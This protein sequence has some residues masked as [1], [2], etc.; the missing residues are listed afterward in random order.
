MKHK[1]SKWICAVLVAA[2]CIAIPTPAQGAELSTDEKANILNQMYL[3]TGDGTSYQLYQPLKRSEAAAFIVKALGVQNKVLQNQAAYA[4]TSFKDVPA[5]EWYAPY[6]GYCVQNGIISGFPDGKYK[7]ND[8]LSEKAFFSILLKALGYT[9]A[10]FTW[11]W[12]NRK[13]YEVGL[14]KDVSYTF[15]TEDNNTYLRSGVVDT[16]YNALSLKLKNSDKVFVENLIN[17]SMVSREFAGRMGFIKNDSLPT[18]IVATKRTGDNL[19]EITLNESINKLTPNDIKIVRANQTAMS[20][21]V[22]EVQTVENKLFIKT[23]AQLPGQSYTITFSTVTDLEQ[24]VVNG[25]TT[26]F[27]APAVAEITSPYFKIAK[28]EAVNAKS[29]NLYFTHPVTDKAETELL[30]SIYLQDNLFL[31]GS[32]KTISVKKSLENSKMVTLSL[33]ENSFVEGTK[34]TIKV[35]GD[36]VSAYQSYLGQGDGEAVSFVAQQGQDLAADISN[37]YTQDGRYLYINFNNKIDIESALVKSNYSIREKE[38]GRM[39]VPLA[40][41]VSKSPDRA[42]REVVIRCDVL[43]NNKEYEIS[44]KNV[45]NQSKLSKVPDQVRLFMA[46]IAPTMDYVV[47]QIVPVDRYTL[48][49][50]MNKELTAAAA[51]VSLTIDNGITAVKKSWSPT[52]PRLIKIHLSSTTPLKAGKIYKMNIF[53]GLVDYTEYLLTK[54]ILADFGGTDTL[55]PEPAV[56]SATFIAADRVLVTFNQPLDSANAVGDKFEVYHNNGSVD[57][58]IIPDNVMIVDGT[59]AIIRLPVLMAGGSYQLRCKNIVDQSGQ[60][61]QSLSSF[62]I[63]NEY[64]K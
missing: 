48:N 42:G 57:R 38:T 60:V 19:V 58:L 28:A 37:L 51:N 53:P 13:A 56:T 30:Y 32:V 54:N 43:N 14:T 27:T 52:E 49:L 22:V 8:N 23:D 34:Y 10:D 36:M 50:Y 20:L 31:D 39:V 3:L 41:Y 33:K 55:K 15:K 17:N 11:D 44:I 7:P 21:G 4:K 6:V 40:V 9:S 2:Q 29:V 25:L 64:F 18:A 5:G 35:K 1:W 62:N 61:I 16:L 45:Y 59:T 24:N 47:E 26:S 63:L 12:I 46:G